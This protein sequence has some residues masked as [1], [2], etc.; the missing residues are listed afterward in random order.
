MKKPK[1]AISKVP[2]LVLTFIITLSQ[3]DSKGWRYKKLQE[4]LQSNRDLALSW[5]E[6]DWKFSSKEPSDPN[7]VPGRPLRNHD[8][9]LS[10][11]ASSGSH[12]GRLTP[13]AKLSTEPQWEP[14]SINDND[15]WSVLFGPSTKSEKPQSISPSQHTEQRMLLKEP[16]RVITFSY[17]DTRPPPV[18]ILQETESPQ[19][20]TKRSGEKNPKN[21]VTTTVTEKHSSN[22]RRYNVIETMGGFG[23]R[24]KT[25]ERPSPTQA[26][27][28]ILKKSK[29]Y[30]NKQ[31]PKLVHPSMRREKYPKKPTNSD[32]GHK[33]H[34]K[35]QLAPTL[36]SRLNLNQKEQSFGSSKVVKSTMQSPESVL[37]KPIT[38][39][40]KRPL[41]PSKNAHSGG[42]K[43]VSSTMQTVTSPVY[44]RPSYSTLI[45][46]PPPT[47]W[48]SSNV[49][50]NSLSR[51]THYGPP[52]YPRESNTRRFV[53]PGVDPYIYH[54]H[55]GG[56]SHPHSNLYPHPHHSEP[57]M[58]PSDH[59]ELG[60]EH[61][62]RP[63][64]PPMHDVPL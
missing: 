64:H 20:F 4:I 8:R 30:K 62:H 58:L 14:R 53:P 12:P 50:Q 33:Q 10:N 55:M 52:G 51:T 36:A 17:K 49:N 59:H 3:V 45:T 38:S 22:G 46:G 63:P 60:I 25:T 32:N 23:R 48:T 2:L 7:S 40:D 13:S 15:G 41:N 11:S 9:M 21:S 5:S 44:S 19:L 34:N 35:Q 56:P 42:H 54:P 29:N 31:P 39:M 6:N 43:K 27:E 28:Q 18:S 16:E 26:V 57:Y 47:W 1:S 61:F 37:R 24:L